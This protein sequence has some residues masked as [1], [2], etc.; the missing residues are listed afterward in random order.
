MNEI[1]KNLLKDAGSG[2][3]SPSAAPI[4]G[5][6]QTATDAVRK[7]TDAAKSV[8]PSAKPQTGKAESG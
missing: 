5:A 1:N 7:A 8:L 2:G 6:L 4:P 3:A